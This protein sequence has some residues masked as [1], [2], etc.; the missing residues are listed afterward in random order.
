VSDRRLIATTRR[1][2]MG[3]SEDSTREVPA[4]GAP[5]AVRALLAERPRPWTFDGHSL[6]DA[7]GTKIGWSREAMVLAIQAI[8]AFDLDR[9]WRP[10]A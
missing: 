8:N 2:R 3:T 9:Q 6:A 1:G 10:N 7:D 5:E 4:D